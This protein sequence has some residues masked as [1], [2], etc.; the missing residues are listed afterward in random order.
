MRTKDATIVVRVPAALKVRLTEI[1]EGDGR[2]VGGLVTW[3]LTQFVESR[4]E[5]AARTRK[6][7]AAARR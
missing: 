4:R 6:P 7:R 1:A 3:V 2:K 5:P